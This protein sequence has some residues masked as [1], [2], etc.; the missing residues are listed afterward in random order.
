MLHEWQLQR[1]LRQLK[2][3]RR[4]PTEQLHAAA[5]RWQAQ[6]GRR[7]MGIRDIEL[8]TEEAEHIVQGVIERLGQHETQK[9]IEEWK[10]RL[11]DDGAAKR[12]WIMQETPMH[13][14]G[15]EGDP[16]PQLLVERS[17]A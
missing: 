15:R 7:S 2:E 3:L 13:W 10:S 16:H 8:G 14:E 5:S 1:F 11:T 4:Q 9:R 17:R 12:R 6:L